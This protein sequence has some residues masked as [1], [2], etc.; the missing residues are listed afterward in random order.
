VVFGIETKER[1]PEGSIALKLGLIT[2]GKAEFY[3]QSTYHASKWDT[4][5]PQ[6]ILE[7]AGGEITDLEGNALDYK[8]ERLNWD[9]AFVATNGFLHKMVIGEIKK[10][11]LSHSQ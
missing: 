2:L 8:K 7:E 1:I 5:A 11:N 6:I 9:K 3:I 10:F 4:C